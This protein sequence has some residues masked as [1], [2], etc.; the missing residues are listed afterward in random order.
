MG[1]SSFE[2]KKEG[3]K[4][5]VQKVALFDYLNQKY[6]TCVVTLTE[7]YFSNRF[8]IIRKKSFE[9]T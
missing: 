7:V 8:K 2:V 6:L 5:K 3:K 4:Q 1:A 9:I